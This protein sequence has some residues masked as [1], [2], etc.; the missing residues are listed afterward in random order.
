MLSWSAI[1]RALASP[2][3]ALATTAVLLSAPALI[4]PATAGTGIES[5]RWVIDAATARSLVEGGAVVLDTRGADLKSQSPL[6][7][8]I[9]V[10]WQ[11]FTKPDLPQK[12]QLLE[13]DAELTQKLQ[14]LGISADVPVLA[15]ADTAKGWGEDGRIVWTLRT[16][17]HTQAFIVDGGIAALTADGPLAIKARATPGTFTVART[18]AYEIKKEELRT[19]IASANVVILDTREPRE[20]AGETPYGESRGGHVPGAKHI[21]YKDLVGTD[22]KILPKDQ[23]KT[24]LASLGVSDD[25]EVVSYCTGGIRSGFVTAVLN[26]AGVKAR[27]YAGSMWEWSASPE[28]Q[29]PLESTN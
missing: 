1:R 12:G 11:D 6:E 4:T 15:V 16:L 28:D 8:A 25:T 3:A 7:G 29:Y 17:G 27:N 13:D 10:V 26:D 18:D 14:A 20:Y 19:E 23:L 24:R 5:S 9:P 2:L 21:F 22:G